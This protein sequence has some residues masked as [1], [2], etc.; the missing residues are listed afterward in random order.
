MSHRDPV[1]CSGLLTR[2]RLTHQGYRLTI[3]R[4]DVS[5]TAL[6]SQAIHFICQTGCY[7]WYEPRILQEVIESGN[8]KVL[9]QQ[10]ATTK[11]IKLCFL[12]KIISNFWQHEKSNLFGTNDFKWYNL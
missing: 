6:N 9:P 11:L 1:K 8:P 2:L 10:I 7:F 5:D 4:N 3:L 12:E